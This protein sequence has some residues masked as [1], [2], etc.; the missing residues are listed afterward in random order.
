M[1][2]VLLIYTYIILLTYWQNS[3]QVYCFAS[4]LFYAQIIL[5]TCS[6]FSDNSAGCCI[7]KEIRA[8]EIITALLLYCY[9]VI[10]L[11]CFDN[12]TIYFYGIST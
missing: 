12:I 7:Y 6:M 11:Y 4:M 10:L 2:A 3:I 9:T 1:Y 8:S 5:N